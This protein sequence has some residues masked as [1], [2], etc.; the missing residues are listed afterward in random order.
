MRSDYWP[1]YWR[2]EEKDLYWSH[3]GEIDMKCILLFCPELF[4]QYVFAHCPSALWSSARWVLKYLA[5]CELITLTKALQNSTLCQY[6]RIY[7]PDCV[8][9]FPRS[10]LDLR[11]R[12]A[13]PFACSPVQ[14]KNKKKTKFHMFK[15]KLTIK[16]LFTHNAT[17]PNFLIISCGPDVNCWWEVCVCVCVFSLQPEGV[18]LEQNLGAKPQVRPQHEINMWLRMLS[19]RVLTAL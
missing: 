7:G 3:G 12:H 8:M 14:K 11:K 19:S 13:E 5:E 9:N 2:R 17:L 18:T 16:L 1:G 4:S 10:S 15:C 6:P